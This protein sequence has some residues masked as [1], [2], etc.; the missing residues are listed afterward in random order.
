MPYT[1]TVAE[2][3]TEL[4]PDREE[5]FWSGVAHATR[6]FMGEAD[7]QHALLKLARL[8]DE[9]RIPYAVI[10]AM[11]LNEYGYRRVTV[12]VDVLLT[13]EGLA[14]FKAAALGRGYVEKFPGSR[15]V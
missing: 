11:A 6:F 4:A 5:R 2:R 14:A 15:G 10:G 9:A 3:E 12:D 13:P 1:R 7:V 8:L